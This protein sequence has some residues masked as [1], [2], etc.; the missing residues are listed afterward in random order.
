MGLNSLS[1]NKYFGAKVKKLLIYQTYYIP[2]RGYFDMINMADEFVIYDS[3]QYSKNGY[4]NRN[5][6]KTPNGQQW[7]TIPVKNNHHISE[8]QIIRE[9]EVVDDVWRRKH[10]NAICLNYAKAPHFKE[11]RDIFENLY[12]NGTEKKLTEINMSFFKVIFEI[13]GIETETKQDYEYEISSTDKNEKLIN[14]IKQSGSD[15]YI[16]SPMAKNY[17]EEEKFKDAGIKIEWMDYSGYPE[18][19]QQYPPFEMGVTILDLI[20]NEGANSRKFMKSMQ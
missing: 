13:L 17:M 3:S 1:H 15:V 14:I 8:H 12:L 11:Y 4:Y 6:I 10:W 19:N 20:F 18:Y 9:T 5:Q 16:S 7:I 2:W